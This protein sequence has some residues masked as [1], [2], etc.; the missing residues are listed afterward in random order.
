MA[1]DIPWGWYGSKYVALKEI[2]LSEDHTQLIINCKMTDYAK[3]NIELW[4]WDKITFRWSWVTYNGVYKPY[5]PPKKGETGYNPNYVDT[6]FWD[7]TDQ[8]VS[9]GEPSSIQPGNILNTFTIPKNVHKISVVWIAS[10]KEYTD[11][12]TGNSKPYYSDEW[13]KYRPKDPNDKREDIPFLHSLTATGMEKKWAHVAYFQYVPPIPGVPDIEFNQD[14]SAITASINSGMDEVADGTSSFFELWACAGAVKGNSA[15]YANDMLVGSEVQGSVVRDK[16]TSVTLNIPNEWRGNSYKVRARLKLSDYYNDPNYPC[17]YDYRKDIVLYKDKTIDDKGHVYY[18][19]PN[20]IWAYSNTREKVEYSNRSSYSVYGQFSDFSTVLNGPP[21]TTPV[22]TDITQGNEEGQVILH[23]TNSNI[24]NVTGYDIE[25]AIRE[26]YLGQSDKTTV[27]SVDGYNINQYEVSGLEL[28]KDWFFRIRSTNSNG[29]SKWSNVKHIILGKKPNVPSTWSE[30]TGVKVG[31][32]I[33]LYWA[34][35]STDG[36]KSTQSDVAIQV[37]NSSKEFVISLEHNNVFGNTEEEKIYNLSIPTDVGKITVLD[38]SGSVVDDIDIDEFDISKNYS[39]NDYVLYQDTPYKALVN[40][41][42]GNDFDESQWRDM[43]DTYLAINVFEGSKIMWRVRTYGILKNIS[44]RTFINGSDIDNFSPSVDYAKGDY[45]FYSGLVYKAKNN[46]THKSFS[47]NDW[48]NITNYSIETVEYGGPSDYSIRRSVEIYGN[49]VLSMEVFDGNSSR[50]SGGILEM[51][52]FPLKV[53]LDGTP[54]NQY[55]HPVAYRLD[56][57]SN[58]NYVLNNYDETKTYVNAG[59]VLYSEDIGPGENGYN[60]R[61]KYTIGEKVSI[62]GYTYECTEN[63]PNV[64]W[65]SQVPP[66]SVYPE[67]SDL[68]DYLKRDFCQYDG[69]AY[70]CISDIIHDEDPKIPYAFDSSK[71]IQIDPIEYIISD[72]SD[73]EDITYYVGDMC[74]FNDN[75]HICIDQ[76]RSDYRGF[77]QNDWRIIDDIEE[78]TETKVYNVDDC[79]YYNSNEYI[80]SNPYGTGPGIF[81]SSEW[82]TEYQDVSSII[83]FYPPIV[84]FNPKAEFN[85]TVEYKYGD[86]VFIN[87]VGYKEYI[88]LNN[89]EPGPYDGDSNKWADSNLSPHFVNKVGF[90]EYDILLIQG[91]YYT[92]IEGYVGEPEQ[93]EDPY[94]SSIIDYSKWR[95]IKEFDPTHN[96]YRQIPEP[97][98]P[99]YILDHSSVYIL[100]GNSILKPIFEV[101]NIRKAFD[102]TDWDELGTGIFSEYNTYYSG[103]S[104]LYDGD[105]YIAV[106]DCGPGTICEDCWYLVPTFWKYIGP[107][108]S[109]RKYIMPGDVFLNPGFEYTLRATVYMNSGLS[110]AETILLRPMWPSTGNGII[111]CTVDINVDDYSA[112]VHPF[113]TA[114][115]SS[116]IRNEDVLLSVYR[117]NPDSTM[118]KIGENIYNDKYA[119]VYDP[120][121]T[122]GEVQYRIV[123]VNQN[124]GTIEYGNSGIWKVK[125]NSIVIQWGNNDVVY[126]INTDLKYSSGSM[127]SIVLPYNI[128]VDENV[129]PNVTNVQYIGRTYPVSYYGSQI[130]TTGTWSTDI[131]KNDFETINSLR[132]LSLYKGDVYVRE[133]SGVGYWANIKITMARTHCDP[134]LPVKISVTRVDGDL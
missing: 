7:T 98:S 124:N 64:E 132:K 78:F 47:Q 134:V 105:L 42:S 89:R 54:N 26:D 70:V 99:Y 90:D 20:Y 27:K 4:K 39:I 66:E 49:V 123:A 67:Y 84:L 44:T 53:T 36:S 45:V 118:T 17:S 81:R 87:N 121:P 19:D 2:R 61:Q 55:Q 11:K 22:Q 31:E 76:E 18:N 107:D 10:F 108:T 8:E 113:Y 40:I 52:A 131:D 80:C 69:S 95:L 97:E 101:D 92:C 33:N 93:G 94:N 51:G 38:S 37:N 21:N 13:S 60:P 126:D 43:S 112:I 91:E 46:I 16:S 111:D 56:I 109:V 82:E 35:N 72:Y 116:A 25:Y 85:P 5:N 41:Q 115:D 28:G 14:Y 73:H 79:V 96:Y 102:V 29:K 58:S 74:K 119:Y 106:R 32:I 15:P 120:H 114:D 77:N 3:N 88:G 117:I 65:G 128:D 125:C 9:N 133:P 103:D 50:P 71:W 30:K 100:N 62:N 75:A 6:W 127:Y 110:K 86:C 1:N 59:S 12:N 104:I 68:S 57:S 129:S 83:D 48:D 130:S 23:W 63:A 122:L 34:N 24:T